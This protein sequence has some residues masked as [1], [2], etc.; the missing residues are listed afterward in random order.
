MAIKKS[1]AQNHRSKCRHN[2]KQRKNETTTQRLRGLLHV[3]TSGHI[4][5][6]H[7]MFV[8]FWDDKKNKIP[9]GGS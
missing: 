4:H 1:E 8:P 9:S 6:K 3:L 2:I 7:E 5:C